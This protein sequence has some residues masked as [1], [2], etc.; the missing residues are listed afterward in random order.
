MSEIDLNSFAGA[1]D[2]LI[3]AWCDRRKLRVLR[4]ILQ[5]Y[6]L[7]TGLTDEWEELRAALR[8]IRASCRD[9]LESQEFD[10]VVALIQQTDRA[11]EG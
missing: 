5:A 4:V 10:C 7:A 9:D 3:D 11:L 2:K 1:M 6:P 8:Q